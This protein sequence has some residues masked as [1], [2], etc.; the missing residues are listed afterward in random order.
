MAEELEHPTR[1]L[2]D[3]PDDEPP[4]KKMMELMKVDERL[5][6]QCAELLARINAL[7]PECRLH[8][9][10]RWREVPSCPEQPP[11]A[12]AEHTFSSGFV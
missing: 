6:S 11:A 2:D 7:P 10:A 12:M 3:D 8:L 1:K 9:Q 5:Q 4:Q